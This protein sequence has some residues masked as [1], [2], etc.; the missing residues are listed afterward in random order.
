MQPNRDLLSESQSAEAEKQTSD[1]LP[2]QLLGDLTSS[3]SGL[4]SAKQL[5][6]K[7]EREP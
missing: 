1:L 5:S 6:T 3:N 7:R 4:S 2:S